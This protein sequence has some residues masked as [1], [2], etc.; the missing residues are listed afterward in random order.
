MLA[1]TSE[2]PAKTAGNGR[3]VHYDPYDVTRAWVRL[4]RRLSLVPWRRLAAAP[5]SFGT[6]VAPL[7]AGLEGPQREPTQE[8][9]HQ[10]V[11]DLLGRTHNPPP[12]GVEEGGSARARRHT[13][14]LSAAP[15]L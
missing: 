3:Q 13:A 10:A 14:I 12:K 6:D 15:H 5:S 8:Q 7:P 4:A 9:I 11:D 1:R 2:E